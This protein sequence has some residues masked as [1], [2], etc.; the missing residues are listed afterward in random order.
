M[1]SYSSSS[2]PH[3]TAS[4]THAHPTEKKRGFEGNPLGS[5]VR[6]LA[7]L[8]SPIWHPGSLH[9]R[10]SGHPRAV[11]WG[12]PFQGRT[13]KTTPG[14][15]RFSRSSYWSPSSSSLTSW[16]AP[17]SSSLLITWLGRRGHGKTRCLDRKERSFLGA[18]TC[19][20]DQNHNWWLMK[21]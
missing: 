21:W 11:S 18:G 6:L 7:L 13:R 1:D 5:I 20:F 14:R 16:P 19:L 17:S 3:R 4:H 2:W 10:H 12:C 8:S 9:G 15:E